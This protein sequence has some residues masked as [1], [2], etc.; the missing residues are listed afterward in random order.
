MD[1][2]DLDVLMRGPIHEGFAEPGVVPPDDP[3][4]TNNTPNASASAQATAQADTRRGNPRGALQ[5]PEPIPDP[6]DEQP[7]EARPVDDRREA[8]WL[9]GYWG[10]EDEDHLCWVSG[11]WRF[12]PPGMQWVPGYWDESSAG[13]TWVPGFWIEEAAEEVSYLPPPPAPPADVVMYR[14]SRDNQFWVPGKYVWVD[15]QYQWQD[16]FWAPIQ[17]DW[18]WVPHRLVHTPR[19]YVECPGYWDYPVERR[20]ALFAPVRFRSPADYRRTYR[21][22]VAVNV[23]QALSSLFV[24][25]RYGHYYYGSYFGDRYTPFGLQPWAA[26]R[27]SVHHYDPLF[28]YYSAT[29]GGFLQ[30]LVQTRQRFVGGRGPE[31]PVTFRQY[32]QS[33]SVFANQVGINNLAS[34]VDQLISTQAGGNVD[35]GGFDRIEPLKNLGSDQAIRNV[36][37]EVDRLRRFAQAR[38]DV[39][40]D[41]RGRDGRDRPD[42]DPRRGDDRQWPGDGRPGDRDPRGDRDDRRELPDRDDAVERARQRAEQMRDRAG[43]AADR[44]RDRLDNV[45]D[46]LRESQQNPGNSAAGDALDRAQRRLRDL[47][48]PEAGDALDRARQQLEGRRNPGAGNA[49]ENR[50]DF[51]GF[52]SNRDRQGTSPQRDLPGAAERAIDRFNPPGRLQPGN[53]GSNAPGNVGGDAGANRPGAP[54]TGIGGRGDIGGQIDAGAGGQAGAGLGAGAQIGAGAQAGGG[55]GGQAGDA[56]GGQAPQPGN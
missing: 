3:A 56:A 38:R 8:V 16:G 40:T 14:E 41:P 48:N 21:P 32:Q 20:G 1:S 31:L 47:N 33:R 9:P 2:V 12:S 29:R 35:F 11:T 44:A 10:V 7:A 36:V 26:Y 42:A 34:R 55:L 18:V 5:L 4:P 54:G 24:S 46:Q 25:P 27:R 49:A 13:W 17:N 30:E 50:F 28:T 43:D 52:R 19:G 51:R 6:I 39:E 45:R 37:D 15:G 23:V 53:A 22:T